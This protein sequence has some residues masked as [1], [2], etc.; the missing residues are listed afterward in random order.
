MA[1]LR[2]EYDEFVRRDAEVIAIGPEEPEAFTEYW[3][4]HEMPFPGLPDP[5]HTVGDLY[6]Q[7]VNLLKL[8]RMPAMM[9]IDKQG[10]IRRA[11]Y[12]GSMQDI[13]HN[14]EVLA[15]LDELIAEE[16]QP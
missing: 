10:T 7:E 13:P 6:Y 5:T 12:A 15:L 1:Q 8:G 11:H 4:E 3:R 2:Q 9:I 16:A 14:D